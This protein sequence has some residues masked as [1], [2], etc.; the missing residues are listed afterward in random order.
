MITSA[1][2]D[3]LGGNSKVQV[4]SEKDWIQAGTTVGG[5]GDRQLWEISRKTNGNAFVLKMIQNQNANRAAL[6][7]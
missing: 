7:Q 3:P 5:K 1:V 4:R 6:A 2:G